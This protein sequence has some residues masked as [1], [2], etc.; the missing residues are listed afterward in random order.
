VRESARLFVGLV[1]MPIGVA[2]VLGGFVLYFGNKSGQLLTFPFAGGL[3]I[4]V[5]LGVM[6]AGVPLAGPRGAIAFGAILLAAGI[7]M[8][9][10]GLTTSEPS[11]RIYGPAGFALALLGGLIVRGGL[12]FAKLQARPT[13][14]KTRQD[15][16]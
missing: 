4:I 1:L 11:H 2:I 12:D 8:L 10:I 6:G 13:A 7:I 5:G 15:R 3:T 14:A 16:G 9:P